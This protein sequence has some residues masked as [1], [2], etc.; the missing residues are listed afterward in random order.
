MILPRKR[1]SSAHWYLW[2]SM[3][4]RTSFQKALRACWEK[5]ATGPTFST[6][7]RRRSGRHRSKKP[8]ATRWPSNYLG[9]CF[10]APASP[11]GRCP[12]GHRRSPI[13]SN[14]DT[15]AGKGLTSTDVG[16]LRLIVGKRECLQGQ[17]YR[18]TSW[19]GYEHVSCLYYL[20]PL[21][22]NNERYMRYNAGVM[23]AASIARDGFI[24]SSQEPCEPGRI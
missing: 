14:A 2:M 10:Q 18:F 15:H 3:P 13:P 5:A 6:V 16:S 8:W 23:W 21:K 20:R 7:E 9:V 17:P 1:C 24:G 4:R 22:D 11:L 19:C 12:R